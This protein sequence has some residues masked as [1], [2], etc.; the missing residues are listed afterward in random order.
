MTQSAFR[1]RREITLIVLKS[2]HKLILLFILV[3][4]LR[5][6]GS[7]KKPLNGLILLFNK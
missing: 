2:G 6:I 5:P 7:Q 1:L 3:F 4:I